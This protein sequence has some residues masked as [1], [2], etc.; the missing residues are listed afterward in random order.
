MESA[1]NVVDEDFRN[2]YKVDILTA[3]SCVNKVWSEVPS[4]VIKNCWDHTGILLSGDNS[5]KRV[6]IDNLVDAGDESK[7]ES[8]IISLVPVRER[9]SVSES[10]NPEG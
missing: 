10:V 7:L 2:I 6:A 4:S 8:Q 1:V 5:S 9:M 3:I